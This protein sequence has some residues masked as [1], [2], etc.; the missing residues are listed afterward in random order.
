MNQ[1]IR[2]RPLR[3]Y[4]HLIRGQSLLGT[5]LVSNDHQVFK[6]LGPK[7]LLE[8]D[9]ID[10]IKLEIWEDIATVLAQSDGKLQTTEKYYVIVDYVIY[11]DGLYILA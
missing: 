6:D 9:I 11:Y 8:I 3:N 2:N 10:S 7:I 4:H 5:D 1:P